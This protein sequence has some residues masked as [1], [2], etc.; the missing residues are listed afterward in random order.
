MVRPSIVTRAVPDPERSWPNGSLFAGT[1][2][3]VGLLTGVLAA[4]CRGVAAPTARPSE[5]QRQS[6]M[7]PRPASVTRTS[8]TRP[9]G[10][11]Q[12]EVLTG[13]HP[14]KTRRD[15][16][17]DGGPP[18]VVDEAGGSARGRSGEPVV[19]F[20]TPQSRSLLRGREVHHVL[21]VRPRDYRGL[22]R[23]TRLLQPFMKEVDGAVSTGAGLALAVLP[24]I[25]L[26]ASRPCTWRA[27]RASRGR[28][29]PDASWRASR[30]SASTANTRGW[31]TGP[32]RDG[33]SVLG[34]YRRPVTAVSPRSIFVTLGTIRPYPLRPA[35]R[36]RAG[37]PPP[38]PRRSTCCGRSA[39]PT[40]G[41]FP[42]ASSS[43]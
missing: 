9:G 30:G 22:A 37:L 29:S 41:I 23:A 43:N 13:R 19:T 24:Q 3:F 18:D 2:G 16:G 14:R 27:S 5:L 20:D 26:R 7:S 15:G 32:W 1:G 35:H 34:Q 38:A 10:R 21:Y 6:G 25:A 4:G 39:A 33:P 40:A 8:A 12:D 31:L 36:H 42:G 17:L 11:G 28:P